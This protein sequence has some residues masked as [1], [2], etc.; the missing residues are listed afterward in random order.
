VSRKVK[1]SKNRIKAKRRLA[2]LQM[3][4]ADIRSDAIHKLTTGV[5]R[6]F[7]TIGVEGLNVTGMM[8]NRRLAR[9][10]ADMGLYESRRQFQYKA[11]MRGGIVVVADQW[12]ASSKLCHC[13]GWKN[14]ALTLKDR[15]WVCAECGTEHD[16]D[17]NA[18]INL[19][20]YAVGHTAAS[21][22]VA[23]CGG[24]GSGRGRKTEVKPSPA[25][26]ETSNEDVHEYS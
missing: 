4:I 9:A 8:K 12:F 10:V 13:C 1:G 11:G 16:R 23:A 2:K 18:A 17:V 26:Q 24:E 20:N 22:A 19:E 3:R 6:R 5:T 15:T 21:S 14:E 7:H 25:K